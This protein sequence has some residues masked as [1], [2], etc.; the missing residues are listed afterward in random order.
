[1]ARI[2]RA[3]TRSP[4]WSR[5][6]LI[7]NYDEWGGFYEHVPPPP[8]PVSTGEALAGNADGLRGFR[9]PTLL[10]SPFARR[11][12][13]ATDV[14]DH[15]SILRMIEKRFSLPSLTVRTRTANNIANELRVHPDV[16]APRYD[17]PPGPF[18]AACPPT[19]APA[20]EKWEPVLALARKF[21]FPV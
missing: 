10:V 13:I 11:R 4:N 1:M 17:V 21:H 7:F 2:Y 12:H 8:G 18:G 9:V 15:A 14:Y 3:V 19:A 20:E 6:V 5:T 16:A